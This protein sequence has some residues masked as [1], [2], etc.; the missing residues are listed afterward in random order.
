MSTAEVLAELPRHCSLGVKK[1]SKGHQQYWRGDKLHLDAADGQI[2]ITA[3]LTGACVHD[4]QVAVPLM[5]ITS[6]RVL[7][8]YDLMDAGYDDNAIRAHSQALGHRSLIQ[9]TRRH[10]VIRERVPIRKD[11]RAQKTVYHCEPI[12]RELTWAEHDPLRERTMVERVYSRPKDE[13]GGRMIRVHG[14]SKIMAHL[15]FEV[16]ALTVDQLLKLTG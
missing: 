2:P 16:V 8:L 1:S 5:N 14:A 9:L 15:M 4:S 3:L 12:Y 11:S 10:R 13:F 7:Y 6:K